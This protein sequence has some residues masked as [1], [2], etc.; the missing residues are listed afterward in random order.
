MDAL[1]IIITGI[2]NVSSEHEVEFQI[3]GQPGE[4]KDVE[5]FLKSF[6]FFFAFTSN[7]YASIYV[8][9]NSCFVSR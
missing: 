6:S 1:S 7:C 5:N 2:F 9:E 4:E 8:T 3:L